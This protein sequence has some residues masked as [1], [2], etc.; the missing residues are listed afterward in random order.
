MISKLQ[1]KILR[2][3][4]DNKK[5]LNET[6]EDLSIDKLEYS[7]LDALSKIVE[8]EYIS[9]ISEKAP[10]LPSVGFRERY[11]I[12]KVY[13]SDVSNLVNA[14]GDKRFVTT[15]KGVMEIEEYE[16]IQKRD[17]RDEIKVAQNWY[18]NIIAWI[19]LMIS[20]LALVLTIINLSN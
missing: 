18:R 11:V 17:E 7:D 8:Y 13:K 2:Y 14:W 3:L 1:Y 19:A 16:R 5:G 9:L 15:S 10:F 4:K 12:D 20:I 6:L